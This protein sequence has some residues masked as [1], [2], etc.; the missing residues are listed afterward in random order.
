MLRPGEFELTEKLI[1][2]AKLT[3]CRILDM[4]AGEGDTLRYLRSRGYEALGIDKNPGEGVA[5][6]DFL[7]TDFPPGSFD[8][9]ISECAFF[10]SGNIPAALGEA[11][12]L[13]RPGGSLLLADIFFGTASELSELTQTA[14]FNVV[15]ILDETPAWREYYLRSVWEGRDILCPEIPEGKC[16]YFL[17]VSIKEG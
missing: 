4:G 8:A 10:V 13:L 15:S 1:K 3:P 6:G 11:Y 16:W 17:S 2:N 14:G 9:I 12:R 7:C 5:R